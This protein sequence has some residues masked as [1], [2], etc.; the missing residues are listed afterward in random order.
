[1][2]SPII[3]GALESIQVGRT[4]QYDGNSD[5]G[6]PWSS[7]IAKQAISGPV[8]VTETKLV[9]DEQADLKHHGG[10]D[11][12]V[13][14]YAAAHYPLWQQ[15]YP[16]RPLG[17][18][19]FGENLTLS[20]ANEESVCIG[21]VIEIGDCQ[22]QI[23]QPRQP[24]WKLD[25]RWKIPKLAMIVQQNGRTGWY[26]RV[27]RTGSIEAGLPVTLIERPFPDLTVAWASRV[28]YA[29]PRSTEDDL[30]L[31]ECEAL[32]ESWKTTL[33]RRAKKGREPDSS[34]RLDGPS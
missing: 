23:S 24:C 26:Y 10:I 21:D 32:S 34:A 3:L 19:S 31:A 27:I 6:K 11:K 20:Q 17:P 13:L 15:E 14:A 8:E 25:R 22:L 16:D 29:K 1:M 18:G 30:R 7:A 9:G 4:R 33:F 28:M 2:N 12:A 5:A